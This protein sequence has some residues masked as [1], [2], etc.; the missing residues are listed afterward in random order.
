MPEFGRQSPFPIQGPGVQRAAEFL[1]QGRDRERLGCADCLTAELCAAVVTGLTRNNEDRPMPEKDADTMRAYGINVDEDG[2]TI[3]PD[4]LVMRAI[5]SEIGG[6]FCVASDD[7]L[8]K[9]SPYVRIAEVLRASTQSLLAQ[10][11]KD[12]RI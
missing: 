1:G 8:N 11:D 4:R 5:S 6:E 2:Y 10:L 3:C 12:M 9:A 7:P